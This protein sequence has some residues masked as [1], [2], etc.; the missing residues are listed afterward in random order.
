M[1]SQ[2]PD[3]SQL[4]DIHLPEAVG[5]WPPAVG[6]WLLLALVMLLVAA[7]YWLRK[8]RGG[9][10]WRTEARKALQHIH[11]EEDNGLE[12]V[13]QLSILLRRVAT[14]RFP[15]DEV[16]ALSGKAWAEFINSKGG[17]LTPQQAHLLSDAP[18]RNQAVARDEAAALLK[19][20]DD[21]IASLPGGGA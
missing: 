10:Q 14:T 8:R 13:Q 1:N 2:A 16:A 6:W 12:V 4:R 20:C 5:W 17:G 21:W 18:Y 9:N 3:L 19:A 15:N 7:V 11:V